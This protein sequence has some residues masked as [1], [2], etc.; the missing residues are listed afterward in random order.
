MK[1]DQY[2]CYSDFRKA[3][4]RKLPKF[5]MDFIDGGAGDEKTL[6]G[7]TA[8]FKNIQLIPRMGS[9]TRPGLLNTDILGLSYAAPYGVASLGLCGLVHPKAEMM[10]AKSAAKY[11]IP[12]IVSSAS[13]SFLDVLVKESGVSPWFQLYLSKIKSQTDVL[14]SH[15]QKHQCPVLVVTVDAPVPGIRRRDRY[16]GLRIP[17]QLKASNVIDS[18]THP[19]WLFRH[20]VSGK[21]TF[22]LYQNLI[23]DQPNLSFSELMSIQTGGELNW[24]VID[25]IRDKW[26]GKLI[27]KGVMSVSD[28]HTAKKMGVDA[29][30]ISNHGGRQL[31]SVP[32]PIT[33][34][35]QVFS[36]EFDREFL[37]L[38]SGLRSGEDII[39]TI[40]CGACFTFLGR[41]FLYALAAYGERGLAQ[42][43]EMIFEQ[44]SVNMRL[45]GASAIDALNDEYVF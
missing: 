3:A 12:Y 25:E 2:T 38:D 22:P 28:A 14:I 23:E 24:A 15:A 1:L 33:L 5:V 35:N 16:N 19:A 41:P 7:N 6:Q 13:N 29:V 32:A 26:Q 44:L 37:M 39:K 40:S 45:L 42:L 36:K 4:R 34:L 30:I 18:V 21:L 11:N 27:L 8:G 10:L 20:L 17:Y 9:Q 43:Q 31:D